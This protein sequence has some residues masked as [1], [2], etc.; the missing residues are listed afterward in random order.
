MHSL[1]PAHGPFGRFFKKL[2]QFTL[3]VY[4][5]SMLPLESQV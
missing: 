5:G 1:I 2:E 4:Y 3:H